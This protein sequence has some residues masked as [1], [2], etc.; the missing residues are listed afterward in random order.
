MWKMTTFKD[1]YPNLT[2]KQTNM[3]QT[4]MSTEEGFL[5]KLRYVQKIVR[6]P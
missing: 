5:S 4:Y 1:M 2:Y 3:S 6:Q